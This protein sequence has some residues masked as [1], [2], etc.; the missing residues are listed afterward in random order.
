MKF[1]AQNLADI[2]EGG[3]DRINEILGT[4]RG[5]YISLI[6]KLYSIEKSIVLKFDP[7]W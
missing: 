7:I 5:L 3:M 6:K 1:W 4:E 2:A